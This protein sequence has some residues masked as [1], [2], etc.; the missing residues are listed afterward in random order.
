MFTITK[1]G[2]RR[3]TPSYLSYSDL[4]I[5]GG[6]VARL[7]TIRSTKGRDS[8]LNGRM[9]YSFPKPEVS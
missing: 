3:Y 9:S 2:L 7:T 6:E 5:V 4:K 1:G 8:E